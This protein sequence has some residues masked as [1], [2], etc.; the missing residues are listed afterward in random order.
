MLFC[1]PLRTWL[2]F[3]WLA[4]TKPCFLSVYGPRFNIWLYLQ[5]KTT[6]TK[7]YDAT[8]LLGQ[9]F[10]TAGWYKNYFKRSFGLACNHGKLG[11]LTQCC[12][13]TRLKGRK[14]LLSTQNLDFRK[15]GKILGAVQNLDPDIGPPNGIPFMD[16]LLENFLEFQWFSADPRVKTI[17]LNKTSQRKLNIPM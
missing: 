15:L 14:Q 8:V 12:W 9:K 5:V 17:F 11:I 4:L 13:F 2:Y 7:K 6:K 16:P 1:P 10:T 3:H